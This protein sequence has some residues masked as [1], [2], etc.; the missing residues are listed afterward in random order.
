MHVQTLLI[1]MWIK[2]QK[3]FLLS[4]DTLKPLLL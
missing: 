4:A 3:T 1:E 2:L